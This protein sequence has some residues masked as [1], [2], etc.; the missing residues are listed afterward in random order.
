[1]RLGVCFFLNLRRVHKGVVHGWFACYPPFSTVRR[2]MNGDSGPTDI[3]K[4]II[5]LGLGQLRPECHD[6]VV[7]YNS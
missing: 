4:R 1:M 2:R 7:H 6:I 5:W 3:L